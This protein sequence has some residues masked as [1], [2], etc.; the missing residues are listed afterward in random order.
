M[1]DTI[2]ARVVGRSIVQYP[3][4][5]DDINSRNTP[6]DVYYVCSFSDEND[7]LIPSLAQKI[8]EAP[9]VIGNSVYVE[10]KLVYKGVHELFGELRGLTG[11]ETGPIPLSAIYPDIFTAFETVIK[12]HVQDLLDTF[13][14]SRGYDGI[15]SLRSYY[16][17]SNPVYGAEGLRGMELSDQTWSTLYTYFQAVIAGTEPVPVSWSEI[18]PLLPSLTWEE[19]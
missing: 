14:Q 5:V 2:F 13:A 4:T 3:M 19:V 18:E 10:R 16:G 15:H 8:I 12:V 9:R 17:S 6:T 11:V 1:H 7:P